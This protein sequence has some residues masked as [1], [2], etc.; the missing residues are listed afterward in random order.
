VTLKDNINR[1]FNLLV[2]TA[3]FLDG[4]AF[5]VVAASPVE[6][7]WGDRLDDIGLAL[8]GIV[9]LVWYLAGRNRFKRSVVPLVLASLAV[10]VQLLAILLERDDPAAF[11]DNYVGLTLL[12]P[13]LAVAVVQYRATGRLITMAKVEQVKD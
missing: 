2:T 1:G 13:L 6:N 3:L 9:G 10:A 12:V 8:V 5:A 4:L 11:G 7:D